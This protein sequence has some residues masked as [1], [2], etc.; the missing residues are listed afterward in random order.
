MEDFPFWN[1]LSVAWVDHL[2]AE[3][4]TSDAF[5]WHYLV[6]IWR[7]LF[8]ELTG[9]NRHVFTGLT[10][11]KKSIFRFF[12]SLRAKYLY[13]LRSKVQSWILLKKHTL[14]LPLCLPVNLLPPNSPK[15]PPSVLLNFSEHL[16]GR[17][18]ALMAF[19]RQSVL[20]TQASTIP[21]PEFTGSLVSGWLPGNWPRRDWSKPEVG[22]FW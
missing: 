1:R 16:R 13:A 3:F 22:S 20:A 10:W 18:E 5:L 14:F 6:I 2:Y 21:Y 11:Q 9:Y 7:L 12:I 4:L 8:A 19:Q 17:K 15:L